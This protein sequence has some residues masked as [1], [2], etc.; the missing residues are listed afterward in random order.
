MHGLCGASSATRNSKQI[1]IRCL[2]GGYL[3]STRCLETVNLINHHIRF[4][5]KEIGWWTFPGGPVV[6]D[7]PSN[8]GDAGLI[9]GWGIKIPNPAECLSATTGKSVCCK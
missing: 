4:T 7:L 2:P 6:K 5:K 9:P 1:E 3:G 8:A